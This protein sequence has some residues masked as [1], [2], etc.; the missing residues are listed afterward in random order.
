MGVKFLS[1]K[2]DRNKG[3]LESEAPQ[4]FFPFPG[5]KTLF[6][7]KL[8]N[9]GEVKTTIK[10]SGDMT[11]LQK[12]L[13]FFRPHCRGNSNTLGGERN[14]VEKIQTIDLV[15]GACPAKTVK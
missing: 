4:D 12:W 6:K 7:K 3:G 5:A 14:T 10:N 1:I 11:V 2:N 13:I 9:K 8:T 15:Y